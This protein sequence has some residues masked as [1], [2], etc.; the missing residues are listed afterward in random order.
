[1]TARW[2]L[3]PL[4]LIPLAVACAG[5]ETDLDEEVGSDVAEISG[6]TVVPVGQLEAVGRILGRGG[7]T[8]T[9]IGDSVVLTAAHCVCSDFDTSGC[10][11]RGSFTFVNVRPVSNPTTRQNVIMPGSFVVH[12]DM[13]IGGC[14]PTTSPSCASISRL[15]AGAGLA[16]GHRHHPAGDREQRDPGRIRARQNGPLGSARPDPA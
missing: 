16:H 6:G 10:V 13:N 12:P 4:S 11:A 9:L 2:F 3:T 5:E 1:M 15:V 8:G 14:W 7:C